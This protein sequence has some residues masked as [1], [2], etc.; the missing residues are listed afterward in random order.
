MAKEDD[1][2][3]DDQ[4]NEQKGK[5][6][7][8][9]DSGAADLEKVTDYVEEEEISHQNI[10]DVSL[11]QYRLLHDLVLSLWLVPPPHEQCVTFHI[12]PFTLY[13]SMYLLQRS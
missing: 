3:V 11:L 7:A 5:K 8:K 9:H 10:G 12:F 13:F 6:V 1:V 2:D 4:V